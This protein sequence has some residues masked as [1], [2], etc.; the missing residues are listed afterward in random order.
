MFSKRQCTVE[1]YTQR[2]HVRRCVYVSQV[3]RQRRCNIATSRLFQS[4]YDELRFFR[5][6]FEH[7]AIHSCLQLVTTFV[8][9]TQFCCWFFAALLCAVKLDV[10]SIAMVQHIMSMISPIDLV[11]ILYRRGSRTEPWGT[12]QTTGRV[13]ETSFPIQTHW[14]RSCRYELNHLRAQTE[15]PKANSRRCSSISWS[16]TS[17]GADWSNI[18]KAIVEPLSRADVISWCTRRTAVSVEW[19]AQ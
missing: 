11:Y 8:Y 16:M 19:T 5:I 2:P 9:G 12:P 10:I 4:K 14:L 6:K 13:L 18:T 7:I 1:N 3:P 17:K 15:I